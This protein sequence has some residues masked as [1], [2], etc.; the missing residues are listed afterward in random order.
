MEEMGKIS[1][2]GTRSTQYHRTTAHACRPVPEKWKP[3]HPFCSGTGPFG[4]LR[5]ATPRA[6]GAFVVRDPQAGGQ[7]QIDRVFGQLLT[8]TFV[9]RAFTPRSSI[10]HGSKRRPCFACRRPAHR[11]AADL[12]HACT[13]GC[14]VCTPIR[15]L[16]LADTRTFRRAGAV[17]G[18]LAFDT[19]SLNSVFYWLAKMMAILQIPGP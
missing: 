14:G 10:H 1:V 8:A 17:A 18:R 7:D 9:T 15:A 16:E 2:G 13:R 3:A 6:W 5:T 19:R 4:S 11:S 12:D